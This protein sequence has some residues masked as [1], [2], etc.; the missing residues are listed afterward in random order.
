[1][2][3]LSN[4]PSLSPKL[5]LMAIN[6]HVSLLNLELN[7][8]LLNKVF[9]SI[10]TSVRIVISFLNRGEKHYPLPK[11]ITQKRMVFNILSDMNLVAEV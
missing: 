9:L 1:M 6:P 5:Y 10:F 8:I 3:S 4:F 7:P 11:V 2:A